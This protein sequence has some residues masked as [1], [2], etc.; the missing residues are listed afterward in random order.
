MRPDLRADR[1][2]LNEQDPGKLAW[3]AIEPVWKS[4]EESDEPA[5]IDAQLDCLTAGQRA[6]LAIHWC[7]SEVSNGGFDQ[8]F[9]N[10]A[11]GL[12]QEAREGF[13]RVGNEVFASILDQVMAQFPQER[14]S[15]RRS[16][17]LLQLR[18]MGN[19]ESGRVPD[20][21]PY[22]NVFLGMLSEAE[23]DMAAYVLA[24]VEEFIQGSS[25]Q[26]G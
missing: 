16:E 24:H 11:G 2:I 7:I 8:F 4:F 23:A 20:F 14:P 10:P 18:Q 3:L 5:A 9:A 21:D 12:A 17:R 26:A 15:R 1:A 19:S 22:N 13:V 25:V 6:L